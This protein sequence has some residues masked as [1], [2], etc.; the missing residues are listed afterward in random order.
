MFKVSLLS[1]SSISH[2]V[3]VL[4]ALA[5]LY[6]WYPLICLCVC[7]CVCWCV[8]GVCVFVGV[9]VCVGVCVGVCERERE[10]ERESVC[11]CVC[12]IP[13]SIT[14]QVPGQGN[15]SLKGRLCYNAV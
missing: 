3:S 4:Y 6:I 15:D 2:L 7:V 12:T 14:R 11:V 8:C 1:G 9:C 13:S 10:R 5:S